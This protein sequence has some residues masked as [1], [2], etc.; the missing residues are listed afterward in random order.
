MWFNKLK[1]QFK[2]LQNRAAKIV[3]IYYLKKPECKSRGF[4]YIH[5]H[6]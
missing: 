5:Y 1:V 2:L 3:V 6:L 4:V